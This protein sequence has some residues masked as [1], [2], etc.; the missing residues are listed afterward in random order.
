MTKFATH[1]LFAAGVSLA[2][3]AI[4]IDAQ[5][6][7]REDS[8]RSTPSA[9]AP[10]PAAPERSGGLEDIVVTAR[11][12]SESLIK[13]PVA[14]TALSSDSLVRNNV[15]TL[16]SAAQLVPFVTLSR[17]VANNGAL[18]SIRGIGSTPNDTGV[19]QSVLVNF[20]NVL[21]GRGRLIQQGLYDL[22]QIEVLKGPQAL[23]YGKNSPAG[24]VSITTA[25][26]G[27]TFGGYAR[28]GFELVARERYVEGAIGGPVA[29]TLKVRLAGRYAAMRGYIHNDAQAQ[30]YPADAV[31]APWVNAGATLPGA[32]DR[33]GPK[34]RDIGFRLTAVWAPVSGLTIKA[35]YNFGLAKNHGDDELYINWCGRG[36]AHQDAYGVVDPRSDC[37]FDRHIT[38]SDFPA[39]LTA[40][41]PHANGGVPFGRLTTHIASVNADYAINEQLA[42]AAVTGFYDLKNTSTFIANQ[43]SYAGIFAVSLEHSWQI[44]QELR[45]SSDFDAPVNFVIGGYVD[46]LHVKSSTNGAAIAPLPVDPATGKYYTY[47]RLVDLVTTSQSIF[48]QIMWD[49]T[50]QLE[51]TGGVRYTHDKRSSVDGNAYVHPAFTGFLRG[52]GDYF[53]RVYTA[54]NYSPEATLSWRPD[55]HQTLYTAYKVGYKSGGFSYPGILIP[56]FNASNTLFKPE[57]AKGIEVGY[58]AQLIDNRLRVELAAYRTIYKNQQ[59]SSFDA[60]LLSFIV[61]N[62][63][64]SRVQGIELQAAFVPVEGLNL[65]GAFGF[66]DAKYLSYVGAPCINGTPAGCT[67]DFRGRRLPRAPRWGGNIGATYE[68]AVGSRLKLGLN[69]DGFYSASYYA[70]DNLD[71]E[72]VQRAFWKINVGVSLGTP[73]DR[74]KISFIGRNLTNKFIQ[75][76]SLDSARGSPGDYTSVPARPREFVLEV[77]SKF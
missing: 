74:W 45:L 28:A 61:T 34:T 29:D 14:V 4:S 11:R 56:Q 7:T 77:S 41:T 25:D 6:Q 57:T 71:P 12:A 49:I 47:D 16:E 42:L 13:V 40:N 54:S 43:T 62:A 24:V 18:L 53:D 3:I 37:K 67:A 65:R 68:A 70:S 73:D 9:E 51:L 52:A 2:S 66:N 48:G 44:S 38:T 19:Q 21:V 33:W 26:P 64:R 39:L 5:A 59:L 32:A 31:F 35:K 75:T 10:L 69:G 60:A 72:Q 58:K 17:F 8:A 46:R 55:G 27:S 36:R 1:R 23:F 20:D 30:P 76:F 63:G 22:S 50:D 15:T